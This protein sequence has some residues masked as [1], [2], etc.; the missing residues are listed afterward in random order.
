MKRVMMFLI[1][2]STPASAQ[3]VDTG[4]PQIFTPEGKYLGDMDGNQ[5]NRNSI[6]NEY[7]P[8][9]NPYGNTVKNP[10]SKY[11]SEYSPQ[12]PNFEYG[13]GNRRK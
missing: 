9:G 6:N 5:Y 12:S 2:L 13:R 3:I 7:G 11:G 1:C 8:Y 4:P 10:Y